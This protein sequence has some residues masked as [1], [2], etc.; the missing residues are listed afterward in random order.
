M[1][2]GTLKSHLGGSSHRSLNEKLCLM[3]EAASGMAYLH[4][5]SII[6]ANLKSSNVLIGPSFE[7]L[8]CDFGMSRIKEISS[9][10]TSRT[11]ATPMDGTLMYK[12]PE[13]FQATNLK[14]A[15]PAIDVYAFAILCCEALK[16]CSAIFLATQ[17]IERDVPNG[18]RPRRFDGVPDPLWA[19]ITECW[20]QDPTKRP[21]FEVVSSRVS[22]IRYEA[23]AGD[24]EAQFTIGK[25]VYFDAK[26]YP[27][28][29]EWYTKAA[30][31]GHAQA[32]Y[33]LS[34][35]YHYGFFVT[36]DDAKAAEWCIKAAKQGHAK[37]QYKAGEYCEYSV[38]VTKDDAKAA[39][40]YIM[41]AEQK[42]AKA[43]YKAG[44]CYKKSKGVMKNIETARYWYRMAA[45]QGYVSA[46]SALDQLPDNQ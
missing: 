40:W 5:K 35:W 25:S 33:I 8:I 2:N 45:D 10:S 19:L 21:A 44:E 13:M 23:A 26:S 17:K 15:S 31:Q 1:K 7:A 38:G 46:Q 22:A 39:E 32:Q 12:A 36:Q 24:P 34:E 18:T 4:S 27:D 16:N 3:S 6:H 11:P 20:D 28:A 29:F 42:Y 9:S 43:Q 37:A 30:N 41:A 14:R